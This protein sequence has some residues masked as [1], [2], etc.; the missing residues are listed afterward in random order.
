MFEGQLIKDL[1]E[2]PNL[3]F[4]LSL[5]KQGLDISS[6]QRELERKKIKSRMGK[7]WSYNVLKSLIQRNSK[8]QF[9]SSDKLEESNVIQI[10]SKKGV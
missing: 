8:N 2:Y 10:K 7:T 4:I 5:W 3:Q 6:I 1:K 9:S